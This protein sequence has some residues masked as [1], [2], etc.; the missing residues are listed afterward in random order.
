L[1]WHGFREDDL[2]RNMGAG[3]ISDTFKINVTADQI[4]ICTSMEAV[5]SGAMV[6]WWN[7]IY[8]TSIPF[9]YVGGASNLDSAPLDANGFPAMSGR[10]SIE[11][12]FEAG[13]WEVAMLSE[14]VP[15]LK[16][17]DLR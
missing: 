16:M 6:Q 14:T 1:S 5:P 17:M 3:V 9:A 7:G 10:E 13:G 2:G 15:V 11:S 4:V 8:G 12:C